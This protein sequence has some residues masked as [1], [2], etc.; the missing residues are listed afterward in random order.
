MH[1]S[2]KLSSTAAT[3]RTLLRAAGLA[4]L[5]GGGV[6]ILAACSP[7]A[8]T[9]APTASAPASSAPATSATASSASATPSPS[10]TAAASKSAKPPNG[11][12][13]AT[14]DVPVGGGVIL[15][16]ANYVIT[17]PTAGKFKAFSKLCTHQQCVLASV[18]DGTINC[19]C[20]GSKFSIEDGAVLTPPANSPLPESKVTVSGGRVVVNE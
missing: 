5:G 14:A 6:A 2:S 3:R 7:D 18:N 4:T 19:G 17:Q 16:D 10:A 13:V 15:P 9:A 1:H 11:P 8:D 20:H 12:S